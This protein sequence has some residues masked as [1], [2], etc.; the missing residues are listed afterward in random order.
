[1]EEKRKK[2]EITDDEAVGILKTNSTA[3]SRNYIAT[4]FVTRTILY[5]VSV[6][7]K[8][9]V[10]TNEIRAAVTQYSYCSPADW[11]RA[12]ELEKKYP[13]LNDEYKKA[14]KRQNKP[15]D[16]KEKGNPLKTTIIESIR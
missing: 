1:M 8:P 12:L 14:L 5:P 13:K 16:V 3:V 6:E 9:G 4:I 7:Y 15:V 10:F 11:E 2:V